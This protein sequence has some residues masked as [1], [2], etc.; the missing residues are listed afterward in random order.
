MAKGPRGMST[1]KPRDRKKVL[2]RL[3][4]YLYAH[5]WL[6]LLA[7]VLTVTSNVLA[8]IGPTLSGWAIDSIGTEP[9]AV[10]FERVFF[11]C[12]L[13]I[14]FYVVSSA[15]SYILS[16]LMIHFSQKIVYQMRQDVFNKLSILPVKYFDNHQ[17]G[18]IVSRI[19]YDIDTI[20]ASLSTDLLQIATSV[21]TVVG[22]FIMMLRISP[23]LIIIFLFT[24]PASVIFTKYKTKQ[25]RPLFS[26]R[27]RALGAMNGYVEEI[28][29]GQ[30]TTKS[31]HQEETMIARFDQKNEDACDAYYRADYFGSMTGPV[32]N[33]IN[34]LS[35]AL[36]SMFGALLFLFGNLTLGNL[37]SFVLYSRKFSGPINEV[38]NIIADLQSAMSAAERVFLLIDEN[39]EPEDAPD[40]EELI[41]PQGHVVIRNLRFGYDPEKPIIHDLSLEAKPG[42]LVAI[43]GPTGAGKTTIINLLMR[44]YDPQGGSI[45]IDGHDSMK[46][47]RKSL[48]KAYSMVLQDTWLFHGTIAENISYGRPDATMEEIVEAAKAAHVHHFIERLPKGY[49]T[50]LNEDGV[51]ISQGQKQLLTIARAM[52]MNSHMLILD[53]AT[54]NVD[55]RT[56]IQI[57]AAMRELMKNKTCFVIAHRLSTIQHA[58]TILVVQKGDIVEQGKH[59]ELLAKGG[60]YAGLYNSQFQ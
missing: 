41:D 37:S 24:I 33:F 3:W 10:N 7:L 36:V 11:Y 13:M 57:Q 15:L 38:A 51:N 30:K 49:D 17:T 6:L 23:R 27:S 16:V 25:V 22:S 55:T 43:V 29:S 42:S 18:D 2:L 39:P 12:G 53:E 26:K 9:G 50:V 21:I 8:L 45:T 52:L 46:L 60:V 28:I 32:V 35:L 5:K 34:N 54:S 20:N 31:Y 48:R 56:E 19:S 1:E 4:K 44:F 40:A 47:T 14:A 59:D 58:D